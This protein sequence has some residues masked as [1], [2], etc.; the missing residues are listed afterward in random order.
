MCLAIQELLA[1]L[2]KKSQAPRWG[3]A[4][5][6]ISAS[7]V[8]ILA[9]TTYQAFV[10]A[11]PKILDQANTL[12]KK[13]PG[14]L[15]SKV[16]VP[17]VSIQSDGRFRGSVA[18]LACIPGGQI[19]RK[20]GIPDEAPFTKENIQFSVNYLR[21]YDPMLFMTGLWEM[22]I[23]TLEENNH[24]VT[25]PFY[26]LFSRNLSRPQDFQSRNWT[27]C[28]KANPNL[29]A[30]LGTRMIVADQQLDGPRAKKVE[31]D[32]ETRTSG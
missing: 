28:T 19:M 14:G 26:Y 9:I 18:M 8:P 32:P 10:L 24:L 16:L 2:H 31:V 20:A 12:A 3:L 6:A 17:N 30:A 1:S 11:N 15:V 7:I 4:K 21:T 25:P 13:E 27:L 29:M 22:D 23:P 5:A